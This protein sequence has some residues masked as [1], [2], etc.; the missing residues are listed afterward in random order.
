MKGLMKDLIQISYKVFF[1]I[2][3]TTLMG[4][5]KFLL[6]RLKDTEAL[7]HRLNKEIEKLETDRDQHPL[8][9][10]FAYKYAYRDELKEQRNRIQEELGKNHE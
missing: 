8:H 5:K 9:L 4:N 10:P 6:E 1:F 7:I 3:C 2:I